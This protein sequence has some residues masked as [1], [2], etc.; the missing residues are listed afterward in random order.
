MTNKTK[1][2]GQLEIDTIYNEECL[3]GMSK[4]ADHSIDCIICDLPYG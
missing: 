2:I 3:I 4:I 1:N